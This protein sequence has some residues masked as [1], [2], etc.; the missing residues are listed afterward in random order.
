[1][2]Q[3]K[4]TVFMISKL[5]QSISSLFNNINLLKYN[6]LRLYKPLR[7][8]LIFERTFEHDPGLKYLVAEAPKEVPI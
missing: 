6:L 4:I 1:M 3:V 5:F 2:Q 7:Q 8:K